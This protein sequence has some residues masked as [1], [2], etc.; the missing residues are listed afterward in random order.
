MWISS[1]VCMDWFSSVMSTYMSAPATHMCLASVIVTSTPC[2]GDAPVGIEPE[3][4]E[5]SPDDGLSQALRL[6]QI[7]WC[8]GVD[9]D[10]WKLATLW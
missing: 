7:G 9:P 2:T 6:S 3:M 4:G 10:A 8:K 1:M 5:Y